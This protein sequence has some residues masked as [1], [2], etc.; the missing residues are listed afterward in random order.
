[1]VLDNLP[2]S[3]SEAIESGV[4]FYFT[5]R[6]CKYGHLDKRHVRDGCRGCCR[7]KERIREKTPE[8]RAKKR[9]REKTWRKTPAG[10]MARAAQDTRKMERIKADP[11]RLEAYRVRQ[12]EKKRRYVKTPAGKAY[13][14]RQSL[15]K[16][17]KIRVATPKWGDK[18]A[19]NR[20][21][22]GCP[23]GHHLDHILPL[24]GK[25][26]CGLHVLE[27]LQYLPA[28]DNIRKSNKVVPITLEACVCPL[29]LGAGS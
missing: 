28:Q 4:A 13:Q 20:F 11:V 8:G 6:P 2:C 9:A 10:K 22:D 19:V 29:R 12:R 27:N 21:L 3:R 17:E 23:E 1:M 25:T 5:G 24:R 16:E 14:R 7:R 18:A 15:A 26:V